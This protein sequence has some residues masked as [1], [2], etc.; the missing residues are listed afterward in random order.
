MLCAVNLKGMVYMK[1]VNKKLREILDREGEEKINAGM[2]NIQQMLSTPEGKRLAEQ[3][4][5]TDREKL[6]DMFVNMDSGEMKKRLQKLDL[7]K[8]NPEDILK[9]LR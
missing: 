9:K 6:A 8:I 1:D 4:K 5:N 7:S 2:R 3:I